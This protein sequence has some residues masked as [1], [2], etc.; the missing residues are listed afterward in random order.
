MT[1]SQFYAVGLLAA[2]LFPVGC[3]DA[4][5]PVEPTTVPDATSSV[6]IFSMRGSVTD[7]AY[8]SLS[9][10]TV[11]ITDGPRAGTATPVDE[12]GFFSMPGT[13]T[14]TVMV[15]ASKDGY[16][17]Q[18]QAVA[19]VWRPGPPLPVEQQRWVA[20]YLELPGPSINIAGEYSL[21]WTVDNA[22]THWPEAARVRNYTTTI[23]PVGRTSFRARL[24]DARFFSTVP[25]PV[26]RPLETCSYN[27]FAI[28]V[29][30]DYVSMFI[31]IIE[32]LSDTS[33]LIFEAAAA[34]RFGF[35]GITTQA[36]GFLEYCT[37][38]PFLIDQGDW[39]CPTGAAVQCD[40]A[41]HQLAL[42][43]R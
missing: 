27:Q 39:A 24:S 28:G 33:F 15:K 26:G 1:S 17:P 34:G 2:A 29:A 37:A 12:H 10:A 30:G 13:F 8:R 43:R 21:R 36:N 4:A 5:R 40:S 20:F 14:G 41:N 31:G 22:C 25:C 38:E 32:Q 18:T 16:I 6:Q 35:D 3:A 23:T 7:T 19:P 42:V 11:E 9:G